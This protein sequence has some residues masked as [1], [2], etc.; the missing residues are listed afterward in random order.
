MATEDTYSAFEGAGARNPAGDLWG[1]GDAG[2]AGELWAAA[3]LNSF[4]K[5]IFVSFTRRA[6]CGE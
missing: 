5:F 6:G 4:Q 2:D 3:N 1:S